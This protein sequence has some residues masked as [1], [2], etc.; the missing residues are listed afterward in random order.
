MLV[1][2][3]TWYTKIDLEKLDQSEYVPMSFSDKPRWYSPKESTPDMIILMVVL[4][5]ILVVV[6]YISIVLIV[7]PYDV[8]GYESILVSM[9]P[10]IFTR[11]R[12]S[13]VRYWVAV[14]FWFHFNEVCML[15]KNCLMNGFT[16]WYLLFCS[17]SFKKWY[18]P[19]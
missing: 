14:G 5:V 12:I 2:V 13:P 18:F 8:S 4:D 17:N 9:Y 15:V 11:H 16:Y 10:L 1:L 3:N 19:F 6:L 7:V